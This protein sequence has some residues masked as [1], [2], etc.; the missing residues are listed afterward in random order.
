MERVEI[1]NIFENPLGTG[2]AFVVTDWLQPEV[3]WLKTCTG[4]LTSK[5]AIKQTE[6]VQVDLKRFEKKVLPG[7]EQ[8]VGILVLFCAIE[9]LSKRKYSLNAINRFFIFW[10]YGFGT[11]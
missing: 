3:H 10:N 2:I 4:R 7:Q 1:Q 8:P 11:Q 9:G 5:I 6:L